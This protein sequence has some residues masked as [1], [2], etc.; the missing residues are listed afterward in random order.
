MQALD[1]T[2]KMYIKVSILFLF[3][4]NMHIPDSTPF[5]MKNNFKN[6]IHS[7]DSCRVQ[8]LLIF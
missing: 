2:F 4:R 1:F 3:M 7:Y 8:V 6:N 5:L